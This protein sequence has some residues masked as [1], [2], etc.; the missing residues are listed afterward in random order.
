MSTI[1][2]PAALHVARS[3]SP[4]HSTSRAESDA[5][6]SSRRRMRGSPADGAG[7]LDL[8]PGRQVELG[9]RGAADR[10]RRGPALASSSRDRGLRLRRRIDPETGQRLL[11][12]QEILRD[13][14]VA[15]ERNL[16][17]RGADAERR[18][19]R[20]GRGPDVP[21]P[22]T[23]ISP[24]SGWTSPLRSLTRV[25]LPAPFSPRIAWTSP[26]ATLKREAVERD[27]GA[28][29]LAQMPA[30]RIAGLRTGHALREDRHPA[31]MGLAVGQAR[32][33]A[34]STWRSR[35]PLCAAPRLPGAAIAPATGPPARSRSAPN[36]G[37]APA[38]PCSTR[39]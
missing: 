16:L 17:E 26:A 30:T 14:Q 6:G 23:W 13:R 32:L 24:A 21:P 10:C 15:D 8:L 1:V 28:E 35:E 19:R 31:A 25:D 9:D 34:M 2:A 27:R 22:K 33:G 37:R 18:G 11:H 39:R 29:G 12:Q 36:R 7:D 4:S 3:A 20:A 5:V 38:L